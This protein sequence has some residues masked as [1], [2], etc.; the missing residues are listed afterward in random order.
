M[1]IANAM[2]RVS[3]H[4]DRCDKLAGTD[5]EAAALDNYTS[6]L[7]DMSI[8][9]EVH[10]KRIVDVSD[11]A[12]YDFRRE[13][14]ASQSTEWL[15]QQHRQ[16]ADDPDAR[17]VIAERLVEREGEGEELPAQARHAIRRAMDRVTESMTRDG[18][19]TEAEARERVRGWFGQKAD[20][21]M[22]EAQAAGVT[23][24]QARRD[25]NDMIAF[26]VNRAHQETRGSL[27]SKR[28]VAA[29]AS[30][31]ALFRGPLSQAEPYASEELRAYWARHGR[32]TWSAYR[33][34]MLG[35][36]SDRGAN[37]RAKTQLP[38]DVAMVGD[39][40]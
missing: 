13:A 11:S 32:L 27:L 31:E 37:V 40:A 14:V 36:A 25:Y 22:S 15:L 23:E 38:N 29:G 16:H 5:G 20:E 18:A 39:A 3:Y 35:R 10:D 7:E 12:A 4:E 26:E 24:V 30:S 21:N 33:Y 28:G 6:A 17:E 2:R 1:S 9:E 19:Y 8:A 34:E